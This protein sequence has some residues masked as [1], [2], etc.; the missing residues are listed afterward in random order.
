MG[1][2][3]GLVDGTFSVGSNTLL[4]KHRISGSGILKRTAGTLRNTSYNWSRSNKAIFDEYSRLRRRF[5]V[6]REWRRG[7]GE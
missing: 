7:G 3:E 1:D 4:L 2:F 6:C 5:A